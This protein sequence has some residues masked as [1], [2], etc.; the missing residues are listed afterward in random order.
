MKIKRFLRL[1]IQAACPIFL[2]MVPAIVLV[3]VVAKTTVY[4]YILWVTCLLIW[5]VI[6]VTMAVTKMRCDCE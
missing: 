4:T 3:E 2:G 1:W 6:P 5:Q